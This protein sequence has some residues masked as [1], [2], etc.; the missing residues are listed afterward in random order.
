MTYM[1][2]QLLLSQALGFAETGIRVGSKW[3][4]RIL[5][6]SIPNS[7]IER[8]SSHTFLEMAPG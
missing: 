6:S 4:P 7:D 5:S 3:V 8:L 1:P 2:N